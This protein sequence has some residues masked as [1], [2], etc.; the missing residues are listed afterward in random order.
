MQ[1]VSLLAVLN[2][3]R[4]TSLLGILTFDV[5]NVHLSMHFIWQAVYNMAS[6]LE[7]NQWWMEMRNFLM[8]LYPFFIFIF[9]ECR[10]VYSRAAPAPPTS[11]IKG[12]HF[13]LNYVS[14]WHSLCFWSV[15]TVIYSCGFPL[16]GFPLCLSQS[17]ISGSLQ[18]GFGV[19]HPLPC[20]CRLLIL[21]FMSCL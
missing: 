8:A 6:D 16:K 4:R 5:P 14:L 11:L 10:R 12:Q 3:F 1:V 15:I 2:I 18:L 19:S 13:R 17:G 20:A 7:R 21:A 9:Y